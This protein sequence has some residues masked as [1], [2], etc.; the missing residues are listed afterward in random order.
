MTKYNEASE[1][2]TARYDAYREERYE[3]LAN[4]HDTFPTFERWL[5]MEEKISDIFDKLEKE[6]KK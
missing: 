6:N 5:E 3:A 2:R 4:D 1:E